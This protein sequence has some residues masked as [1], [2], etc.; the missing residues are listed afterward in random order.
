[1]AVKE[2]GSRDNE[3]DPFDN[4][5]IEVFASYLDYEKSQEMQVS[6]LYMH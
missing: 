1:M 5:Y 3:F 4:D 2:D 6:P